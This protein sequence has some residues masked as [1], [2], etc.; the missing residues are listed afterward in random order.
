MQW[1]SILRQFGLA[2]ILAGALPVASFAATETELTPRR[3]Q[4]ETIKS[5]PAEEAEPADTDSPL[6][7]VTDGLSPTPGQAESADDAPADGEQ[8]D[9]NPE[10]VSEIEQ[11]APPVF[12][13]DPA[14]LPDTVRATRQA[15]L[16]AAEN[17]DFAALRA[18]MDRQS[19]PPILSFGGVEDPI[20]YLKSLAGDPD[21]LEILAILIEV[22]FLQNL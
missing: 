2:A 16:D 8:D 13:L 1:Q 5:A 18:V 3:V 10:T 6:K 9:A 11:I 20:E 17:A 21:G 12:S 14:T 22:L 4:T 15:I 7:G 19:E